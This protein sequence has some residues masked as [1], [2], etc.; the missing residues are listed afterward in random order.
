MRNLLLHRNR[1]SVY[2]VN[3][4]TIPARPAVRIIQSVSSPSYSTVRSRAS[5]ASMHVRA[6]AGSTLAVTCVC[7]T[8]VSFSCFTGVWPVRYSGVTGGP[9]PCCVR[10]I[11][12][13]DLFPC[14][15]NEVRKKPLHLQAPTRETHGHA[16]SA[17]LVQHEAKPLGYQGSRSGPIGL[18]HGRRR[19]S[20]WRILVCGKR[21][22]MTT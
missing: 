16:R 12:S 8:Y 20:E 5:Q 11:G 13:N 22:R 15:C 7:T 2:S 17:I 3:S 9:C 21:I 10:S 14:V 19:S 18:S 1:S 4:A 6:A